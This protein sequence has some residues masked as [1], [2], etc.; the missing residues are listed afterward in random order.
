M[1]HP[2]TQDLDAYWTEVRGNLRAPR[3]RDIQPARIGAMLLDS[4]ILECAD[5]DTFRFRLAGT[6]VCARFGTNLRA[7]NFLE[8]WSEG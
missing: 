7:A 8:C 4:F 5:R 2:A 6:R 1:R 3:R